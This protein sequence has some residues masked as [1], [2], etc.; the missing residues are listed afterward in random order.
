MDRFAGIFR[1]T[2]KTAGYIRRFLANPRIRSENITRMRFGTRLFQAATYTQEDRYPELFAECARRLNLFAKPRILSF[3]C[4]TGEELSTLARY[5]PHA[6]LF[7]VDANRWC[8][9]QC[10]RRGFGPGVHL[11]HRFSPQFEALHDLDAIFCMAV[12]QR[13]EHRTEGKTPANSGFTFRNFESEIALL[14]EKLRT[15]GLFFLDES[16]FAFE[17]TAAAARYRALDFPGSRVMRE[18][19]LFDHENRLVTQSGMFTRAFI[20]LT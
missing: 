10:A 9:K 2:T 8:L 5:L 14:D 13:T 11:M 1:S 17:E 16:D 4:S 3:G 19:P 7:G 18:R 15:G 20:K 12:F 6:A